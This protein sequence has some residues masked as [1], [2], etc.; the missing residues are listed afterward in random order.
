MSPITSSRGRSPR[1]VTLF[2]LGDLRS[3]GNPFHLAAGHQ[4]AKM[5]DG[6]YVQ[7]LVGTPPEEPQGPPH[8]PP[9]IMMG[10]AHLRLG[11][12]PRAGPTVADQ[13]ESNLH[14]QPG[15]G[16]DSNSPMGMILLQFQKL[17]ALCFSGG[18]SSPRSRRTSVGAGRGRGWGQPPRSR[19]GAWPRAD[20]RSA[21]V[22]PLSLTR[23][24][25]RELS[26]KLVS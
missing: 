16:I 23:H 3:L 2:Q 25:P 14:L 4:G 26:I 11:D 10:I 13:N 12:N 1:S 5:E 9:I 6:H 7:L 19:D 20:G 17:C 21:T 15:L 18:R 8:T 22:I 24:R